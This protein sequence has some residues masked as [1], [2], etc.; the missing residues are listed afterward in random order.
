MMTNN[1]YVYTIDDGTI[2]AKLPR[3][4]A[5]FSS[6]LLCYRHCPSKPKEEVRGSQHMTDWLGFDVLLDLVKV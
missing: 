5:L 3:A 4:N 6:R 2:G 1:G